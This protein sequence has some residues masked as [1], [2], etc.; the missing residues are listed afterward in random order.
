MPLSA[1]VKDDLGSQRPPALTRT[2][3]QYRR[4]S[5][6][7]GERCAQLDITD[8]AEDY[9]QHATRGSVDKKLLRGGIKGKGFLLNWPSKIL[10]K[11]NQDHQGWGMKSLSKVWGFSLN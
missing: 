1:A 9:N 8:T 7:T 2:L 4:G 6:N 3:L 5:Y 10:V 11:A